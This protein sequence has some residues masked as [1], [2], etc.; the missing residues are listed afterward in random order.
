MKCKDVGLV[1]EQEGF[2]PLPEAAKEHVAE[3]SACRGL[4]ADFAAIVGAAHALP[5]EVE[6]PARLWVALRSQLE[7][8][9]V[10]RNTAAMDKSSWLQVLA[11]LL[12]GR[13]LATAT[14]G[15]VVVL[16][17]ALVTRY[18][19]QPAPEFPQRF[20]VMHAAL[21]T[22]E[23]SLQSAL[24]ASNAVLSAADASLRDNLQLVNR[25]IADCE[26]RV[27][28]EPDDDA[29]QEYLNGA[30]QQKSELLAAM[31]ERGAGGE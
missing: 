25:F 21:A 26:Q 15:L 13:A 22:Q 31:M 3:C 20:A 23:S 27:Q 8:E 18:R 9:G 28:Q 2:A 5:A 17:G 1:L 6:P 19:S 4:I 14:V 29:A 11:G 7:A 12:R 30:Y 24:P 16:A 10:I